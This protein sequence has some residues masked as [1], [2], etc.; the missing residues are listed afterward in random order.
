LR[1]VSSRSVQMSP[2]PR[3]KA[4]A[5]KSFSCTAGSLKLVILLAS[6]ASGGIYG[7]EVQSSHCN[8]TPERIYHAHLTDR[9]RLYHWHSRMRMRRREKDRRRRKD[10]HCGQVRPFTRAPPV[11]Y[12]TKGED[13]VGRQLSVLIAMQV[14]IS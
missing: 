1:K 2:A 4:Y 8:N 13:V 14:T 9:L 5:P 11:T 10:W 6:T 12:C 3:A 7:S